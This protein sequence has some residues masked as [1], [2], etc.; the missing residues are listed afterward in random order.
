MELFVNYI[1]PNIIL[2]GSLYA[3]AKLMEYSTQHY[4]NYVTGD[5]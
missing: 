3:I 1:V 5:E 4:I 2:F